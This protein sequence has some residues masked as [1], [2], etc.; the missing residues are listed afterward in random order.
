MSI[1]QILTFLLP[2]ILAG[3]VQGVTGFGF[4]IIVVMFFQCFLDVV[5]S[6][7]ISQCLSLFL[8]MSLVIQYRRHIQW[9]LLVKPLIFYFPGYFVCLRIVERIDVVAMKPFL[10][11]FLII[12]SI[13]FV[14][15]SQKIKIR[16]T[17]RTVIVCALLSA[18]CDAAFGIGGPPMVLYMLTLSR[19]REQYLATVQGFFM[20]T[21]F[22]GVCMRV[23]NGMLTVDLLPMLLVGLSGLLMGV[24]VAARVVSKLNEEKMKHLVYY[25]I[26]VAG[27]ITLVNSLIMM[28]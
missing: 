6:A 17:W 3:F 25:G 24:F 12:L 16:D 1:V 10:G 8:C 21:C 13:Y 2:S 5:A 28:R 18:V 11:I 14:R 20:V 22:Y 4:G 7:S 26:G 23:I 19:S 9:K 27:M 15:F